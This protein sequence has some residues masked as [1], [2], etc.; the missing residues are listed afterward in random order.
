MK[1][2]FVINVGSTS[3]K[4]AYYEDD[5]CVIKDNITHP[6]EETKAFDDV[7]DQREYRT[8][9]IM[10]FMA[11]NNLNIDEMDAIVSRGGH[12]KPVISGAYKINE[13]MIEQQ[14]SGNYG[15]HPV[16][17]GTGIAFDMCKGHKAVPV[18][19]DP[20]VADEF[21]PVA[22]LSG[23]PLMPREVRFHVLSHKAT[24]KRY[25]KDIGKNYEDL[26]L[27][28]IHMGGGI[29]TGA[30]SGGKIIDG[31]NG[32]EGEGPY[33]TNRTGGLMAKYVVDLCFS[34]KY[35]Q[36][37][38]SKMINGEGGLVAYL[39]ESDVL[40]VQEM[41]KTDPYAKLVL[42][43]MFY[44]ACKEAGALATVLKGKIDAILIT[45]GIAYGESIIEYMKEGL[46]WIA[47]IAVYP[48][49][50]EMESLALGTLEALNNPEKMFEMTE[51]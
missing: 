47:P 50:N 51:E 3:T 46:G 10:D 40:K 6:V 2:I 39:G 32:I 14:K 25:A 36:K 38:I 26:N 30:H 28:T 9:V 42:E 7:M 33:S 8:K 1:K 49:E 17:V 21:T 23:H 43:G 34:G 44:Q 29:T 37:E 19:V 13:I 16:D 18:T 5:K 20:P 11:A 4:V 35:T 15:R 27:I 22:H 41:G 12:T 24:A 31:N 45:G 48:G